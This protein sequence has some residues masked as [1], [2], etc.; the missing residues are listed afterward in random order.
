MSD[1]DKIRKTE[2]ELSKIYHPVWNSF[3]KD[4]FKDAVTLFGGRLKANG[5]DLE[6]F[7]GKKCIDAGCGSGRYVQAMLDL[8]AEEVVGVD[9]DTAAAKK[10]IDDKR[11]TVMDGDIRK[12]PYDDG[13]FDFICCNGVVHHTEDPENIIAELKRLL[14]KDGKLF[15]YVFDKVTL[16]WEVLDAF[17]EACKDLPVRKVYNYFKSTIG[18]PENKL[19][20]ICDLLYAPIQK[21]YD[22][23]E[24]KAMLEG[25]DVKFFDKAYTE[26]DKP[27]EMR[28]VATKK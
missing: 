10:M 16:D 7:K 15:L 5:F 17:R 20:Q 4:Q 18:L 24:L 23:T 19:F 8:G 14:K 22:Q 21:K 1:E 25:F 13:Y 26:Y 3:T 27:E 2:I 11:A 12:I 28:L 6:W 9:L